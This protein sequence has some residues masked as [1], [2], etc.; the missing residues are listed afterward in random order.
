MKSRIKKKK[1]KKK[2]KKKKKQ[3]TRKKL[4]ARR[5]KIDFNHWDFFGIVFFIN[6]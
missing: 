3:K 4:K 2:N 5:I 6:G 1:K